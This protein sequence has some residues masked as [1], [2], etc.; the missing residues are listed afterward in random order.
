MKSSPF[1]PRI[2][3]LRRFALAITAL[4]I[5]GHTVFGFEQSWAHPLVALATAYSMELGLEW[6]DARAQQRRPRFLGGP[7]TLIDFLLS[8]HITGLAVAMLLYTNARLAPVAFAVAVAIGSKAL[9][10]V[11]SGAGTRHFFNPSN[12]GISVTLLAFPWVGI[13]PPYQFTENLDRI[14]DVAL[15][16]LIIV[17]GTLLNFKLTGRGP[18]IIGWLGGFV[19]QAY[20]RNVLFGTAFLPALM[21]MTGVAF[22]L[23]TFYMVTD[24][25]TTPRGKQAQLVYGIAV[26]AVYGVLVSR[27]IVFGTFF[28]LT[29]VSA[30]RACGIV[31]MR[32]AGTQR[33]ARFVPRL[34][35]PVRREAKL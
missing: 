16:A 20:I 23:F 2:A 15:P 11:K 22:I 8:A 26:A 13:A 4:N 10:R 5:L 7:R 29:L 24:P 33:A 35:R 32:I 28:A 17:T 31:A 21:P 6:L 25:G 27:H 12:F 3:A 34:G 19:A 30:A 14:G 18:L 9:F 1:D